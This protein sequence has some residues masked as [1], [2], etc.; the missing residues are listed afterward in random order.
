MGIIKEI[1]ETIKLAKENQKKT[2]SYLSLPSQ[3]LAQLTDS[4]LIDVLDAQLYFDVNWESIDSL[5]QEQLT[6]TTIL[7]F[8]REIQNG[9]ICQFFVNSSR[10]FSP[11]VS[12]SLERIGATDIQNIFDTFISTN[13]IDI[14]N[15]AVL[16]SFE[17]FDLKDFETQYKRYPFDDFDNAFMTLYEKENL[18]NLLLDY[19]RKN[20]ATV[21][22]FNN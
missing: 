14:S 1:F 3:E 10:S 12:S 19:V 6:V 21:F 2:H 7:Q 9:G 20:H 16:D 22:D 18:E 11:F 13:N 8:D 5:N 17:I 15:A 4:E